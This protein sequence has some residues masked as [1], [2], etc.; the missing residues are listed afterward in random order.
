MEIRI[1]RYFWTIAEEGNISRAADLLHITQPTLSRQLRELEEELGTVLFY[2]DKK[3]LVLTEAGTFLKDRAEEILSLT[4]KTEQAFMDQKKQL[5]SGH[6]SIGCVEADNS[7][8]LALMLEEMVQDYP[9]VTF[10]IFSGTSD[11]ITEKLDKGLIDLAILLEPI[12]VEKYEGITLPRTEKWG[13]VVSKDS[14]LADKK[15]MRPE[16]LMGVPLLCS[17]RKEI[18]QMIA[19]W[20]GTPLEQ[21][22]ITGTYNLI[23]NIFSL[24]ENRVGSALAIEGA[25]GNRYADE[26]TF[27]PLSPA[28]ETKCVAAWKKN[29]SFSPVVHEFIQRMKHAFKA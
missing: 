11:D 4:D 9:Q 6:I 15:V 28:I 2:R 26:I 1:L 14:F 8:T 19:D 20:M 22:N 17:A 18:Q 29:R 12:A 3:Q 21:L 16:D 27:I 24:V 10:H 23:F 5:F 13:I 25:I 7:D